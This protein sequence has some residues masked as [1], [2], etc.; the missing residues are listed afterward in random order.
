MVFAQL[1][2]FPCVPQGFM[3]LPLQVFFQMLFKRACVALVG[4]VYAR[5]IGDKCSHEHRSG[6]L[7]LV[8]DADMIGSGIPCKDISAL[9][10]QGRAG[11]KHTLDAI[12]DLT[13]E[14]E[15]DE[16]ETT[17]PCLRGLM[18]YVVRHLPFVVWVENV[19]GI[20]RKLGLFSLVDKL[21]EFFALHGYLTWTTT[22]SPPEAQ[23]P[24]RRPRFFG[25]FVHAPQL[26]GAP[27]KQVQGSLAELN[28]VFRRAADACMA[29]LKQGSQTHCIEDYMLPHDSEVCKKWADKLS[30][31]SETK[32]GGKMLGWETEHDAAFLAA[33]FSRPTAEDYATMISAWDEV[34][35]KMFGAM[36]PRSREL[37]FYFTMV[38][39]KAGDGHGL[40]LDVS[41]SMRFLTQGKEGTCTC[42]TENG[43][44]WVLGLNHLVLGCEA[45][46]LQGASDE[47]FP[48]MG[49]SSNR[50][51]IS[52]AGNAYNGPFFT[53]ILTA[54]FAGAGAVIA[55]A[56]SIGMYFGDAKPDAIVVSGQEE[57]KA[58]AET[59]AED[60]EDYY[61]GEGEEEE[62]VAD[63]ELEVGIDEG[64]SQLLA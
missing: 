5:T 1:P 61:E 21:I 53:M 17:V 12:F 33:G 45:M 46:A 13:V 52:L 41:Q 48:R 38:R 62:A 47:D 25:S 56:K 58:A 59:E 36:C 44:P 7:Q 31:S 9:S 63:E 55:Y 37:I 23:V 60:V 6:M 3:R 27:H 39:A 26:I 10:E 8:P 15:Y 49:D 29:S 51:L 14:P 16:K 20:L 4:I 35:K 34:S 28:L 2:G 64:E 42:L 24:M 32:V 11:L 22:G 40:I 18:K 19:L 30:D 43:Q 54:T 50:L 57:D